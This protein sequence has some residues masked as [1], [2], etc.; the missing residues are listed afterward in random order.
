MDYETHA[1]R[2]A[3]ANE[4]NLLNAFYERPAMLRLVGDVAGLAVLDAG[5]GHGPLAKVLR[6]RGAQVS[7]FDAS[8]AMARL[9]KTNLGADV[10]V[11]VADLGEALPYADDSFD[12]IVSSL[13]L[14]YLQDWSGPLAELRRVL[15]CN[16]RLFVSVNH[17]VT[18]GLSPGEDYF[19]TTQNSFDAELGDET[20]TFTTWHRPLSAMAAAFVAAGF[21]IDGIDEPKIAEDTPP[22]LISEKVQKTRQI[23]AMLF[24]TLTPAQ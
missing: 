19:A 17:P 8:P 2:Y 5:C 12:V 11:S 20:V 18:F 16:G 7:A 14:H 3:E 6:D 9:A 22:D 24:F 23:L 15:K 13:S 4:T 10:P 21:H 1:E